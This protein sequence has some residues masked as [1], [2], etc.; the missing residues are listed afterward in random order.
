MSSMGTCAEATSGIRSLLAFPAFSGVRYALIFAS[1]LVVVGC[2]FLTTTTA[3]HRV[4][5]TPQRHF[6]SSGQTFKTT[7][8]PGQ[9]RIFSLLGTDASLDS[10]T[11]TIWPASMRI[12]TTCL[13]WDL[14]PVSILA[15]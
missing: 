9:S 15:S 12:G 2:P 14:D 6:R 5:R 4:K 1:L 13:R 8:T 10:A 11:R 3:R 7:V